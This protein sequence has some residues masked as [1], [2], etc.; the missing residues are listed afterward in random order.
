MSEDCEVAEAQ[1]LKSCGDT[2][3]CLC[4]AEQKRIGL[5]GSY[6]AQTSSSEYRIG[7][8]RVLWDFEVNGV[9]GM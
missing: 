7:G 8:V 4:I 6:T 1:G 3:P 5:R 9:A 2:E